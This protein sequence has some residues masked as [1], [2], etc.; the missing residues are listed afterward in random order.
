MEK[1]CNIVPDG[2][3]VFIQRDDWRMG[4]RM[5]IKKEKTPEMV[6]QRVILYL[7]CVTGFCWINYEM[8][9]VGYL[10]QGQKA[11]F[12]WFDYIFMVFSFGAM[13]WLSLIYYVVYRKKKFPGRYMLITFFLV[14]L[15]FYMTA[16]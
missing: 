2:K 13:L 15:P 7:Y 12:L 1:S 14:L 10:L 5:H 9:L 6:L 11:V 3:A 8:I 16:I 4:R